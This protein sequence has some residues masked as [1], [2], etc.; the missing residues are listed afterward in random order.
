MT[1][2]DPSP[3]P[4]VARPA[5]ETAP[6]VNASLL[7]S[8]AGV[9]RRG[10]RRS[11][12]DLFRTLASSPTTRYLP[13]RDGQAPIRDGHLLLLEDAPASDGTP[14]LYL[15]ATTAAGLVPAGTDVV[16][17]Q[18]PGSESAGPADAGV[19][20]DDHAGAVVPGAQWRGLR[21]AADDLDTVEAGLFVESLALHH[22]HRVHTHCP[23]C[24]ATT[25]VIEGG[26]VRRCTA[27]GSQHFPR[28]DPAIICTVIDDDDRLLLGR[29]AQWPANRFSTLAGFVEPGESL[30]AAVVRE[31]GEEAGIDVDRPRYLGSQPWP[32]PC[33]LM[34]GFTAHATGT[35]A[36]PDGVEILDLRWF[37]RDELAAA[38]GAGEVRLPGTVSIAR[39]LIEHWYGEPL[40]DP[41]GSW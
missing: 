17:V 2:S 16:L 36:V 35:R 18:V 41:E 23:R 27:D 33:S 10:E 40:A 26:W 3:T 1:T 19:Y 4:P 14:P 37:T 22:W 7:L 5:S 8:R 20:Q 12:P 34:L 39:R 32:F 38:V 9:D 6:T 24:G 15:G 30:E 13:L 25:E 21:D 29:S 31:I 11:D 28:T